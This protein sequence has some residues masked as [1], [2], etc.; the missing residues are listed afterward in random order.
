MIQFGNENP[1]CGQNAPW[2]ISCEEISCDEYP[3]NG[4]KKNNR[5][6]F[7]REIRNHLQQLYYAY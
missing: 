3:D 1:E 5:R 6:F 4:L 2:L 7:W